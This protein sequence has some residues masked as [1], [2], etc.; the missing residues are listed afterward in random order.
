MLDELIAPYPDLPV[1]LGIIAGDVTASE[2]GNSH[3]ASI[4]RRIFALPQVEVG[5]HTYTHIFNWG[6]FQRYSRN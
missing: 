6:L 5:S 3:S 2:G 1:T 4:A